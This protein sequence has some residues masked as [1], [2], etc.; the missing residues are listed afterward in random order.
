MIDVIVVIS[1]V[2]AFVLGLKRGLI[3]QLCHLIG[4]YVAILIAPNLAEPVGSLFMDDVGKAYLAGFFIIVAVMML[5]VWI[6][7]PMLRKVVI[8]TPVKAL[9]SVLGGVLNVATVILVLAALFSVFDRVNISEEPRWEKIEELIMDGNA[10]REELR[11]KI[12]SLENGR[13]E[14]REYFKPRLVEYET[15]DKSVT[16]NPLAHFG[17]AVC[18]ALAT[19]DE[20]IQ[21]EAAE[22]VCSSMITVKP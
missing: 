19:I 9:D 14:M 16:F 2:W 21:Q 12:L 18:P 10:S 5:L 3:V 4:I 22:A 15:L 17:D 13:G 8:W 7:A 6:V 1:V 11:D 20:F